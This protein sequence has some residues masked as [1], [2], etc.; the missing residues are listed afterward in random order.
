MPDD[1]RGIQTKHSDYIE[2][3]PLWD[4]IRDVIAGQKTIKEKGTEYL[5][6]LGGQ[7]TDQYDAYKKR[8]TFYNA[9]AQTKSAFEGMVF[10][11]EP[12]IEVPNNLEEIE[13][14]LSLKDESAKGFAKRLVGETIET[15]RNGIL[16]DFPRIEDDGATTRAEARRNGENPYLTLYTAE[17]IR[18]WHVK[19]ENGNTELKALILHEE[20]ENQDGYFGGDTEEQFRLLHINDDGNYE[21]QI[22][23]RSADDDD[24]SGLYMHEKVVP[25]MG[26]EPLDGIPF[27]FA[28]VTDT[29]SQLQKPP[30]IDLAEVNLS[31]Y[32]SEADLEHGAHFTALPT[33]YVIGGDPEEMEIQVGPESA[34]IQENEDAEVG[35]LEYEGKGLSELMK[36]LDRK[37]DMMADMG[38]RMVMSREDAADATETIQLKQQGSNSIVA[39]IADT[40]GMA[41]ERALNLMSRWKSGGSVDDPEA[42]VS[43]NTDL[44]PQTLSPKMLKQLLAALQQGRITKKTFFRNLQEGE[45]ID[46]G[47]SFDDYDAQT[48]TESTPSLGEI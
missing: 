19:R 15:G 18:N 16:V 34:I 11:K 8:A 26:G 4:K 3:E 48:E 14:D 37:L 30:L 35:M 25:T 23:R 20:F 31:H 22:W 27:F 47:E 42:N 2:H 6:K 12:T 45:I 36:V 43:L 21:Q 13:D 24:S 5:P 28:G 33:I 7:S 39:N 46:Q 10:R 1:E 17:E 38:A 29:T 9:T 44:L 40:C 32:R 41:F